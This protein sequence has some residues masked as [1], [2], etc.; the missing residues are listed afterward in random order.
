MEPVIKMEMVEKG[1]V[2]YLR[3]TVQPGAVEDRNQEGGGNCK[4]SRKPVEGDGTVV[5]TEDR[6]ESEHNRDSIEHYKG[7]Y[8]NRDSGSL[9]ENGERTEAGN[10][11]NDAAIGST[12]GN[13]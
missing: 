10:V 5:S 11:P 13:S 9:V 8:G 7:R 4:R 2:V 6:M 1:A 12:G 3:K